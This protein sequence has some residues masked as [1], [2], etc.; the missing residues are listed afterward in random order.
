M[1]QRLSAIF[2]LFS[3]L[4]FLVEFL[5]ITK[6]TVFDV[7]NTSNLIM[8]RIL[9]RAEKS[10]PIV[11]YLFLV[12]SALLVHITEGLEN[13]IQD[14][15]HHAKTKALRNLPTK[16]IQIEGLRCLYIFTFLQRA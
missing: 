5:N 13:V 15:V 10:F 1:V 9:S 6:S 3:I 12:F 8:L 4:F 7:Y 14:Y 2:L 16:R 11:I